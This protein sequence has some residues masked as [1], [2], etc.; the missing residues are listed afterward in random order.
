MLSYGKMWNFEQERVHVR[1]GMEMFLADSS[2][3]WD[4]NKCGANKSEPVFNSASDNS[5]NAA[6]RKGRVFW[7]QYILMLDKGSLC[8]SNISGELLIV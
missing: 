6:D 1:E 4:A 3:Y 2:S 7:H 8:F 5:K